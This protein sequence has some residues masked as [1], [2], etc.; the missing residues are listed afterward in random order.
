MEKNQ[1]EEQQEE[2]KDYHD[3]QAEHVDKP[4]EEL[5]EDS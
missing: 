2:Q 4:E 3:K 5:K 1:D